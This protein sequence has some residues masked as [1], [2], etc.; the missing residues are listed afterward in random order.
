MSRKSTRT[1]SQPQK[2]NPGTL[3]MLALDKLGFGLMGA[4]ILALATGLINI[5]VERIRSRNA[6]RQEVA[7]AR[8][9]KIAEVWERLNAYEGAVRN[10]SREGRERAGEPEWVT[11]RM[12]AALRTREM[13][14]VDTL[15]YAAQQAHER[16]WSAYYANRSYADQRTLS[17]ILEHYRYVRIIDLAEDGDLRQARL[18]VETEQRLHQRLPTGPDYTTPAIHAAEARLDTTRQT[19]NDIEKSVL[20]SAPG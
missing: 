15:L 5:Q 11:S 18:H 13:D 3:R 7:K 2:P 10:A 6:I 19:A 9:N 8:F 4:L 17:Q 16:F 20:G 1:H 14:R 12:P